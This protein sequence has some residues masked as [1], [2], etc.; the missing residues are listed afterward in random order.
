[1]PDEMNQYTSNKNNQKI[2][3]SNK[4]N[5]RL[6]RRL[7][8]PPDQDGRSAPKRE[9]GYAANLRATASVENHGA[10]NTDDDLQNERMEN[11]LP[12]CWRDG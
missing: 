9:K 7:R 3:E 2:T 1:M 10:Q 4:E 8:A 11:G 6:V 12:V 5:I